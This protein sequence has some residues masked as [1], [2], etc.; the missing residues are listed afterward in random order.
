M[1]EADWTLLS[2]VLTPSQCR[3]GATAGMTPPNGGGVFTY[4]VNSIEVVDGV[5]ALHTNQVN[6]A[7]TAKGA[8][9]RA[10]IKRGESGGPTSFAP[11]LF[12]GLDSPDV[13]GSAYILGL[14]DGD[15]HRVV[16]RKGALSGGV[17][18]EAVD[19]AVS[20][21]I[22]LRSSDTYENDTWLHLRL[23][24]ILQGTGDV[25]LQCFQND[26][27]AH[28]VSSP[29]WVMVPGM[30][31]PNSPT[32]DGFVD[33]ALGVNTGSAPFTSGYAGFGA[34]LEAVTRRAFWDHVEVARQL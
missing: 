16:L 26:L 18:D 8:S 1:A 32:V 10:A 21:N 11:F 23:D 7:P 14:S 3:R 12:L 20:P 30:E 34:K 29:S 13:S 27:T 25:I 19:P 9:I 33:D 28:S 22:L 17:P 15:P 6:F 2:G 31:G 5:V 24:M 4:G